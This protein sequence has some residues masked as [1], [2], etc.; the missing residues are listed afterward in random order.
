MLMTISCCRKLK[1]QRK[2]INTKKKWGG[3]KRCFSPASWPIGSAA[4]VPRC[5]G[6]L[7]NPTGVPGRPS[8]ICIGA[9]SEQWR[10]R[11]QAWSEVLASA[12]LT[13]DAVVTQ[14][15]P[16][17]PFSR[18]AFQRPRRAAKRNAHFLRRSRTPQAGRLSSKS[19]S[20]ALFIRSI[21]V[22][23]LEA[24]AELTR[25]RAPRS[26]T[27]FRRTPTGLT[28]GRVLPRGPSDGLPGI[29]VGFIGRQRW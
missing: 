22:G 24:R 25:A 17:S 20:K 3:G 19:A 26:D 16:R 14:Q 10:W 15:L 28:V 11:G 1:G 29:P 27:R 21:P 8:R 9:K 13:T 18:F 5:G 2:K 4:L 12:A 6:I 7:M 23:R